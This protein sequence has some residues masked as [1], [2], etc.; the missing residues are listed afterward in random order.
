MKK[1]FTLLTLILSQSLIFAQ[2]DACGI[3]GGENTCAD[4]TSCEIGE[5]E[6]IPYIPFSTTGNTTGLVKDF[7]N[8]DE[9]FNST[10]GDYVYEINLTEYSVLNISTCGAWAGGFDPV[11]TF[12]QFDDDCNA[13]LIAGNDDYSGL[14]FDYAGGGGLTEEEFGCGAD[15]HD[16]DS[17]M[18]GLGLDAGDYM[19]VVSGYSS[20]EGEFPL[21]IEYADEGRIAST[22]PSH[23]EFIEYMGR[24]AYENNDELTFDFPEDI[25]F[26]V[27]SDGQRDECNFVIGP[28]AG[29]DGVCFS[30]VELDCAGAC[31]G[32]ASNDECGVCNGDNSSCADCAGVPNGT[33]AL[34]DCGV[35]DGGNADQDCAG[36]CFGSSSLDECGECGGS[37]P[38]QHFTCSGFKPETK[39]ALQAAVDL[40]VSSPES[41]EATYGHISGWDVSLITDMS[42]L[43]QNKTTFNDN[44]GDWDVS[45]V[46]GM[47]N[48]FQNAHS[49]NQDISSWDISSAT[50]ISGMF[51]DAHSFNQ[52]ISSWNVSSIT[53]IQ[54]MFEDA[55]SFN[56]DIS[57]WDVSSVREIQNMFRNAHSFNQDISSW[58]V[59]SVLDFQEM[60]RNANSLSDENKCAIHTSFSSNENWS[61]DNSG[62]DWTENQGCDG[63]CFSG[64]A[65]DDCGVCDGGGSD[66][67]GCGC[68]EPGP[69][70]CD[71]TCGSTLEL[72][73]CGECGGSGPDQH[74]TCSG[75]KPE[76]KDA[77]QTAVD[78][79][80]SDNAIA[81]ASY[82]EIN[83]WD[84]SL[85]TDLT[86]L[87]WYLDFDSNISSWDVSNV[88]SMKKLF[89][90]NESF[91]QD[92]SS[93]DV[94]NVT[95]MSNMFKGSSFN[96]DL[97]SWDV[98]S[99]TNMNGTFEQTDYN[100]DIS[101]WDV[102]N[103]TNMI[104]MFSYTS[105][106]GD[107]SNWDVSS[108]TNMYG[109]F[110]HSSGNVD[111]SSWDV[112]SVT[113]MNRMFWDS[114]FNQ[115]ISSW[116]VS[117]VTNMSEMFWD[118]NFNQ[119][120]SSWDVS[121]VNTFNNMFEGAD[122][123]SDENQCAIH[124]SFSLNNS[125]SYNWTENQGCDG[126]CF[127]GL[128]VDD[129]DVCGGENVDMDCAG[130]CGG[131]SALDDCGV[132][133]GGNADQDCAGVCFGDSVID[134]CGVC[135]GDSSLYGTFD[136]THI[137]DLVYAILENETTICSDMDADGDLDIVD[138]VLMVEVILGSARMVDA[139]EVILTQDNNALAFNADGFVGGIQLTLSHGDNFTLELTASSMVSDFRTNGN[140][141]TVIIA[142]PESGQLFTASSEFN[143]ENVTAATSAGEIQVTMPME[144]GLSA[145]YPN[146]FN[147]S[148]S[149]DLNMS[150]TEMVS[151]DVYNVMG[152]LVST[153]H[154]GELRAGV[155]SFTWNGAE[156][157]SG[158]YFIRATTASSVATQKVM[159]MK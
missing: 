118:S 71:N 108:V 148:T 84:V 135:G 59:S 114:N 11:I 51:A 24:K 116:D 41:T 94:S 153:I 36:V 29:C 43:F 122:A 154:S 159:L 69:S 55:H 2:D 137:V 110:D 124:T 87:F 20:D 38:D 27:T 141:T 90:Y 134:D 70:G 101:T 61:S 145:A 82:G 107:L 106:S 76:T 119:D 16:Y 81:L 158:A 80:V 40:W 105:F 88:T 140:S 32:S 125:W 89:Y 22:F 19:L 56:Q 156:I 66:D 7:T 149:F 99:V 49:F 63:V 64:L 14:G 18:F 34:D 139:S 68:F 128:V 100:G 111:L 123:L 132:C 31:G 112:S 52:D 15:P 44:I 3:E 57:I 26:E 120:I 102:S 1:M 6:V 67:L 143:I 152:Q 91:N 109:T 138:I 103:V 8:A 5:G 37:G 86:E 73:E 25:S 13:Q 62:Y 142:A 127:S 130:V 35:C 21:T 131:S 72:D 93:W 97:N 79:W 98:S 126:V 46:T 129:C 65:D 83:D 42:Y 96:Q 77:L 95:D 144:F 115:D 58:D 53:E 146:P 47:W 12:Y 92:I 33:S 104:T 157:A 48:M 113:S 147:P 30:G 60:F 10:G 78:L 28:D 9:F 54:N 150:S 23:D 133:D 74:F 45:S 151:V 39:D 85:M 17:A 4:E 117:S 155:H 50:D 121:N 136:I 75:F